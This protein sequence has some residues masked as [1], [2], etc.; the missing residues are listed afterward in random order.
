MS[1]W[2]SETGTR[3]STRSANERVRIGYRVFV[4]PL[5][6]QTAAD[7]QIATMK[8]EGIMDVFR[9]SEPGLQNAI[10]LGVY[11]TEEAARR[12]AQALDGLFV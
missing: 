6:S 9:I 3:A 10:A 1:V 7:V 12:R 11:S 4:P 2:L 8:A 5:E